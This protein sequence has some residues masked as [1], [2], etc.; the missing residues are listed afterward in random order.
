MHVRKAVEAKDRHNL[1]SPHNIIKVTEINEAEMGATCS[2]HGV[3]K[4]A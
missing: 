3:N 1:C 2:I 4:K